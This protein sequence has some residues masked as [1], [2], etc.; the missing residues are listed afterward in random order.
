MQP[1]DRDASTV[2]RYF[3]I[4]LAKPAHTFDSHLA[5]R[6]VNKQGRN[7]PMAGKFGLLISHICSIPSDYSSARSIHLGCP[8]WRINASLLRLC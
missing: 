1:T 7:Y 5:L 8:P 4:F 2:D 6:S 3:C